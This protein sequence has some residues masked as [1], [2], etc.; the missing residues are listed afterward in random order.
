[1]TV[2]R[3]SAGR[4]SP[5]TPDLGTPS[6]RRAP[7]RRAVLLVFKGSGFGGLGVSGPSG[8]GDWGFSI[9]F[10][11]QGWSSGLEVWGFRV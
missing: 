1:M 4:P 8:L 11:I 7:R 9:G 5:V 2:R 3:G 6:G 10:W